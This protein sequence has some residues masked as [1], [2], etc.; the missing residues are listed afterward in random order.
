MALPVLSYT[1]ERGDENVRKS[2]NSR[3]FTSQTE[4]NPRPIDLLLPAAGFIQRRLNERDSEQAGQTGVMK[5]KTAVAKTR[6]ERKV[7][8]VTRDIKA[9]E[10]SVAEA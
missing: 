6:L 2:Y 1:E 4:L 10:K 8:S 7:D 5:H 9:A 3:I